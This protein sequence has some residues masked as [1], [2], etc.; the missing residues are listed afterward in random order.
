MASFL[1]FS[2]RNTF[3]V[4]GV[5][6]ML[7]IYFFPQKDKSRPSLPFTIYEDYGQSALEV[8]SDKSGE[9]ILTDRFNPGIQLNRWWMKVELKND[10]PTKNKFFLILNN[11]HINRIEVY[12]DG[13]DSPEFITG[14]RFP[15]DSRPYSGRDFVFPFELN[16]GER[17]EILMN[18]DKRGETF[19]IDPEVL[20]ESEF[21][22]RRRTEY[23]I[24]GAVTGWMLLI[25]IFTVFFLA[26][27]RHRSAFFYVLYILLVF[28]WIFSN[29]GMGSQYLWPDNVNWVGKSRPVF[30]LASNLALLLTVINI[31]KT[32]PSQRLL[33]GLMKILIWTNSV[34]LAIFL[35]IPEG[36]TQPEIVAFFLKVVLAM[37]GIQVITIVTYLIHQYL[38]KIQF[39]GIYLVGITFLMSS[40]ILVYFDQATGAIQLSHYFLNFGS[41]FGI[42]GET[43]IFAFAFIRQASMEKKEKEKLAVKIFI[44]EKEIADQIIWVQ[45]EERNRLGRD[46]HDS[47]GGMLVTIHLKL[48]EIA[49]KNHDPELQSLQYLINE[50]I[51][52]TRAL[53]HNLT[54]P[55]L[56]EMGLV[57]AL[58]NRMDILNHEGRIKLELY[59]RIESGIPKPTEVMVYRIFSELISNSLKHAQATEIHLQLIS[60]AEKLELMVE[61]DGVG[62][63]PESKKKGIGL[64]NIQNR[65][66]YLKGELKIDSNSKGTTTMITIPFP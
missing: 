39:A 46:L 31:F 1:V 3:L 13:S 6:S 18:L 7:F 38:A 27:L 14:D 57:V 62:F 61:D 63:H 2:K 53:S 42:M 21:D 25:T 30:N 65:V 17:S 47:V 15:F 64:K 33:G 10:T 29:W 40:S 20:N 37:S 34:L 58:E 50:G 51:N 41:A 4:V 45:E 59:H 12:L 16:P 26:E 49:E 43:A 36:V 48:Q 32:L 55:H 54:P 22:E 24:M 23:L 28:L 5:I 9:I 52:D 11:P 8:W 60:N 56:E 66:N 35:I 19:H 44:R